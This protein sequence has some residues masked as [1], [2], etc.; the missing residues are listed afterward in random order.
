MKRLTAAQA[1]GRSMRASGRSYR[2]GY[3]R[4]EINIM[5]ESKDIRETQPPGFVESG[6]FKKTKPIDGEQY[7]YFRTIKG[8]QIDSVST[9]KF[10]KE[11]RVGGWKVRKQKIARGKWKNAPVYR[12]W[13]RRKET[14]SSRNLYKSWYSG[15]TVSKKELLEVD[16]I[17]SK[18]DG[19]KREFLI[20]DLT[21][22]FLKGKKERKRGKP[23]VHKSSYGY[24]VLNI[25]KKDLKKKEKLGK[26]ER[27]VLRYAIKHDKNKYKGYG[28]DTE[29]LREH[30]GIINVSRTPLNSLT[31]KGYLKKLKGYSN[32]NIT[33]KGR[34]K[35]MEI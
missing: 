1:H 28:F 32:W 27:M 22:K 7:K 33:E 10:I 8:W 12:F 30:T 2:G 17:L 16:K 29:E 4:G 23:F 26:N 5:R 34:K 13:R 19:E 18:M 31:R 14:K 25:S 6:D 11:M 21:N 35:V 24:D 9:E 20:S 3:T 15:E